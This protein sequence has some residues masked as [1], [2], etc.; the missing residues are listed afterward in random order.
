[1][2]VTKIIYNNG[3][4]WDAI[5]FEFDESAYKWVEGCIRFYKTLDEADF[6]RM[7]NNKRYFPYKGGKITFVSDNVKEIAKLSNYADGIIVNFSENGDLPG[8]T[9]IKINITT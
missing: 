6:Q 1:M 3:Q 7:K 8:K 9:T 4:E 5:V 2:E